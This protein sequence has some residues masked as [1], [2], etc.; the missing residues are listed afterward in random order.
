MVDLAR[1][2]LL[3]LCYRLLGISLPALPAARS[4]TACVYHRLLGRASLLY[5][6]ALFDSRAATKCLAEAK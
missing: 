5:S 2:A 6:R 4:L 3:R 1:S